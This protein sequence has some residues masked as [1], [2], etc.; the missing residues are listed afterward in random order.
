MA[1]YNELTPIEQAIL[2][3]R[4]DNPVIV[5]IALFICIAIIVVSFVIERRH[6]IEKQQQQINRQRAQRRAWIKQNGGL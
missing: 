5:F 3:W 1:P 4:N 2:N 6:N